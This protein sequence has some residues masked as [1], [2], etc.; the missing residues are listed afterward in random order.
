[1]ARPRL[2]DREAAAR[3]T[4]QARKVHVEAAGLAADPPGVLNEEGAGI[5]RELVEAGREM[6]LWRATDRL[7]L[8]DICQEQVLV[9]MYRRYMALG[10]GYLVQYDGL[11]TA[12]QARLLKLK[13]QAGLTPRSR[14]RM[15]GGLERAAEARSKGR[16]TIRKREE[17]TLPAAFRPQS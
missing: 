3:G 12:A 10:G 17:F 15:Q 4:R 1:M 6:G 8:L 5:W 7:L 16:E 2:S 13:D 14:L 9:N 11:L